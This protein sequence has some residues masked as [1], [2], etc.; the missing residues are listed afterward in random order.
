MSNPTTARPTVTVGGHR[1]AI[2]EDDYPEVAKE[3]IARTFA[4]LDQVFENLHEVLDQ[5]AEAAPK[6]VSHI[7]IL[8]SV[9]GYHIDRS[10]MGWS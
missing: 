5:R 8:L 3:V 10:R 1:F 4:D 6:V 7:L 2:G 9:L